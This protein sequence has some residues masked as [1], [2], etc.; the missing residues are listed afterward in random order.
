MSAVTSKN[1]PLYVLP[2]E[3]TAFMVPETES[4]LRQLKLT[5]V[6]AVIVELNPVPAV[7]PPARA[8]N[9]RNAGFSVEILT[10]RLPF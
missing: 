8:N 6:A 7:Q 3:S 9:S 2:S 1:R 4:A 5:G 10:P